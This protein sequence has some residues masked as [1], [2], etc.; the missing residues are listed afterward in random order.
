MITYILFNFKNTY[1]EKNTNNLN[2]IKDGPKSA[3]SISDVCNKYWTGPY[4]IRV[5]NYVPYVPAKDGINSVTMQNGELIQFTDIKN[6][7]NLT[8]EEYL[9][10][11]CNHVIEKDGKLI[12]FTDNENIKSLS[13]DDYYLYNSSSYN[14]H[15]IHVFIDKNN[16]PHF[17]DIHELIRQKN[18]SIKNE[19]KLKRRI[20]DAE[21]DCCIIL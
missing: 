19:N 14:N 5:F 10:R 6:I 20:D 8:K 12:K 1:M 18:E 16:M 11:F 3:T 9:K 2:L 21:D 17:C 15:N 4:D 7:K 13:K